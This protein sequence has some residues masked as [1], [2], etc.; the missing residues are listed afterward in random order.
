MPGHFHEPE[1]PGCGVTHTI[2]TG[3]SVAG[4]VEWMF[5]PV[6]CTG[7]NRVRSVRRPAAGEDD[8][9]ADCGSTE[10]VPWA[11]RVWFDEDDDGRSYERVEGPCP[12][13]QTPLTLDH[14]LV[15]GL[16]D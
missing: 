14:S 6:V 3:G 7:C 5:E 10:V 8:P 11:G 1:C 2:Y 4:G 15:I 12:R 16:W 9:C 13:C